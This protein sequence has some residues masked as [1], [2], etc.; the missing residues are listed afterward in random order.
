MNN[1]SILQVAA[2]PFPANRGTPSRILR[3]SEALAERGHIVH[4]ATYHLGDDTISVPGALKIHRIDPP[5]A[6]RK[7]EPGPSFKKPLL[8]MLLAREIVRIIRKQSIDVVHGHHLEGLVSSLPAA[9]IYGVPTLYDAHTDVSDE[10]AE[11][12]K[13]LHTYPIKEILQAI[14]HQIVGQAEGVI[15]VSEKLKEVLI[16]HGYDSNDI[17]VVPTGTNTASVRQLA[18]ESSLTRTDIRLDKDQPVIVYTGTLTPYQGLEHLLE[19]MQIVSERHSDCELL[20][21]GKGDIEAYQAMAERLGVSDTVRFCGEKPFVEVPGYL[22]ISDIAVLPRTEATGMPQK[23]TNYM[24][25]GMPIVAFEG[26]GKALTHMENGYLVKDGDVVGF[27]EGICT[28]IEDEHL[29][30]RFSAEAE[31]SVSSYEWSTLIQTVAEAYE[32]LIRRNRE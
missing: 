5:F 31:Q 3:M 26:S 29:R 23:L 25:A 28:L 20:L 4:I 16:S 12:Y 1:Y 2:C 8:D 18:A 21:V 19:A 9:N 7:M 14:E 11:Y 10:L 17:W 32:K 24:A 27:A 15:T 22:A 30:N 6:Y 13:I